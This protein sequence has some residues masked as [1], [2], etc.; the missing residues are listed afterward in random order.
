MPSEAI[1]SWNHMVDEFHFS[2]EEFYKLLEEKIKQRELP[3]VK[4]KTRNIS[5]GGLLSK[6]RLYFEVTRKDYIFHVCAAPF[7]KSYF[8]SWYLRVKMSRWQE[9]IVRIPYIGASIV[10]NMQYQSYYQLDTA[11]MFK[12]AVHHCITDAIDDVLDP[13]GS[14]LSEL[15]RRIA[16]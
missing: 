8:F 9:L 7:G 10:K 6:K 1:A 16:S 14:K 4:T 11:N 12:S 5:Q 3:D 15:E 2:T 13:K